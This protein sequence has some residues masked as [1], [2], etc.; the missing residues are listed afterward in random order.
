MSEIEQ[1][2]TKRTRGR[3]RRIF[4]GVALVAGALLLS[5]TFL[6]SHSRHQWGRHHGGINQAASSPEQM[7]EK[8][9]RGVHWALWKVDATDAQQDQVNAI[10]DELAPELYRLQNEQ[11]ALR[12]QFIHA[13]EANSINPNEIGGLRTASL[14]LAEQAFDQSIDALLKVLEVL[15]PKQRN[16]LIETWRGRR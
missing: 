4:W 5:S 13:L 14:N 6:A 11:Q 10:L 2:K 8:I 9:G 7:R 16:E 15:T 3:G 1:S 12:T